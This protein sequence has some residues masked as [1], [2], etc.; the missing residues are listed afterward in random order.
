MLPDD[1]HYAQCLRHS[2]TQ[3]RCVASDRPTGLLIVAFVIR[4][5]V[6]FYV[7]S[8]NRASWFRSL[9]ELELGSSFSFHY[10]I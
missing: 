8:N 3:V 6:K 2:G 1:R 4:K 9:E 5:Q 10:D 7:G